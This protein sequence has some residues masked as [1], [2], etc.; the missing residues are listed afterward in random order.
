[1]MTYVHTIQTAVYLFPFL[2]AVLTIPYMIREYRKFGS[3]PILRT[4]IIY[5]F[6]FYL[7]CAYF[8]TILPL[9][10]IE[11][12]A[13][14]TQPIAELRPFHSVWLILHESPFVANDPA[15]Y[16]PTLLSSAFLM[17]FFNI[18]LVLPFG[19]YLRYYF[20]RTWRQTVLLSFLL[21][22][23]FELIQLSA[24]F[25]IYPRPYRLFEVDDLIWN[26]FGGLLGYWLTPVFTFFLPERKR[27]DAIA[28]QRGEQVSFIRRILALT[29]D[30][31]LFVLSVRGS[32]KLLVSLRMAESRLKTGFALL[33]FWYFLLFLLVPLW[34]KGYTI[35][36]AMV[37]IR[38]ANET[39]G[40]PSFFRLLL[41]CVLFACT[42]VVLPSALILAMMAIVYQQV[43]LRQSLPLP[44]LLLT[45]CSAVLYVH[46]LICTIGGIF[47]KDIQ[48][49]Y[50]KYSH[51]HN[52][53]VIQARAEEKAVHKEASYTAEEE[54]APDRKQT[55]L[56]AEFDQ[57]AKETESN[58]ADTERPE[59]SGSSAFTEEADSTLYDCA[60]LS[61]TDE[62]NE[63]HDE[64][65]NA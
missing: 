52:I 60:S 31:L 45:G 48:P 36:K 65:A 63:G 39:G 32:G 16:L 49:A 12:A 30:C 3:I 40:A 21:S 7:M 50:S 26:T 35:G 9:P 11:E 19:V 61:E 59:E 38:L 44:L 42:Y 10:S 58:R 24:L 23:S 27:L 6:I 5:S 43:H 25:G 46:Q 51:L 18:L 33:L 8:M 29:A 57:K 62:G 1:M 64:K 34:T 14:S 20:R 56:S 53:S 54:R 47:T 17:V 37:K 22:L 15:T 28:Y 13:A 41:R 55:P 2:A 4:L